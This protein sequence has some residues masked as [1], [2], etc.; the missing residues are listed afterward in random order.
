MTVRGHAVLFLD[1]QKRRHCVFED[2]DAVA[3]N[4]MIKS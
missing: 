4:P 2:S 3:H 1:S